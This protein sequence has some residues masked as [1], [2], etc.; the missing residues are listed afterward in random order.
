MRTR[1][2]L[3]PL[4]SI[5]GETETALATAGGSGSLCPPD[6]SPTR[7]PVAAAVVG[8]TRVSCA[9]AALSIDRGTATIGAVDS[10]PAPQ[11]D[12]PAD[13]TPPPEWR[14][15]APAAAIVRA[16]A[17]AI[18]GVILSTPVAGLLVALLSEQFAFSPLVS[19]LVAIPTATLA[20]GGLGAWMG[21]LRWKRTQW[22]LDDIGLHVRRGVIWHTDALVPRSRVQHLDVERGPLERQFSLATLVVHTAGTQTAA[23]R[24]SG[25]H[26]PDAMAL[27]DALIPDASRHVDAL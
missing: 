8:R 24:L 19:G 16:I 27:R 10:V 5:Y 14:R 7:R 26:D 20:G 6:R 4:A 1:Q 12:T 15:L 22:R 11:I 9:R 18:G 2:G 21:R 13:T 23:L 3:K 25:L 17:G